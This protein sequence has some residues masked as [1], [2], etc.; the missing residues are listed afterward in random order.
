MSRM[1]LDKQHEHRQHAVQPGPS[2][3]NQLSSRAC[4]GNH[5]YTEIKRI[6]DKAL[7]L[8]APLAHFN[9]LMSI[10]CARHV[11]QDGET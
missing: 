5:L 7:E 11:A 2:T 10:L 1:R 9:D 4:T 8:E 3:D 6:M